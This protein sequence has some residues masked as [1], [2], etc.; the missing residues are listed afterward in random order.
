MIDFIRN[1]ICTCAVFFFLFLT[2]CRT[3]TVP[4]VVGPVEKD[5]SLSSES[6]TKKNKQSAA[7]EYLNR[8]VLSSGTGCMEGNCADGFGTFKYESGEVYSGGFR[9]GKRHG[10]GEML[11]KDGSMYSGYFFRDFKYGKGIM[12]FSNG[13]KYEGNFSKGNPD[14]Q[15]MYLFSGGESFEGKFSHD[16]NGQLHFESES[17]N[18]KLTDGYFVCEPGT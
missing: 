6:G 9:S 14:G 7:F 3:S 2:G 17:K 4:A 12:N 10:Y 5:I 16:E 1:V 15:G 11:Y 18:C 13:D 8:I